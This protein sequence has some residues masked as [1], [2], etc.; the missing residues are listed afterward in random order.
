MK[1]Y[2]V[3][4]LNFVT[5]EIVKYIFTFLPRIIFKRYITLYLN[6]NFFKLTLTYITFIFYVL[7]HKSVLKLLY[8]KYYNISARM[9]IFVRC[10]V[11][12]IGNRFP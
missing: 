3:L 10:S 12:K 4:A 5:I 1:R 9:T 7:I 2:V 6:V 11:R 8:E